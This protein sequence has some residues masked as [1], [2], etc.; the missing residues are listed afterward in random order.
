MQPGKKSRSEFYIL[1]VIEA[2][3][4]ECEQRFRRGVNEDFRF[5]DRLENSLCVVL[6]GSSSNDIPFKGFFPLPSQERQNTLLEPEGQK[7]ITPLR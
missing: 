6:G 5:K 3:D 2:Y 7:E 4:C 1:K